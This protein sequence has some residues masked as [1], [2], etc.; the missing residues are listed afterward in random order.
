MIAAAM[1][2][3][4]FIQRVSASQTFGAYPNPGTAWTAI[5]ASAGG[6]QS[7]AVWQW[8]E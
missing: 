4:P 2:T 8:T 7:F 6:L 3:T 1:G 5:S